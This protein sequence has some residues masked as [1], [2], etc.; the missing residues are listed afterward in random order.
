MDKNRADKNLQVVERIL[1]ANGYP[2]DGLIKRV[3]DNDYKPDTWSSGVKG[4]QL[5]TYVGGNDK[6]Y[7]HL[8]Y[9]GGDCDWSDSKF[10]KV[11]KELDAVQD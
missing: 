9:T 7:I 4:L 3:Q 8:Q 6:F 5:D 10:D 11:S 1:S 2:T